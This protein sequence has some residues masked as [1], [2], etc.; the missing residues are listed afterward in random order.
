LLFAAACTQTKDPN[1]TIQDIPKENNYSAEI[2]L[3][4]L[5]DAIKENPDNPE[6][7]YQRGLYLLELKRGQDA[8]KDAEYGLA[9]DANN[10]HLWY[11]KAKAVLTIPNI[12]KSL[13]AAQKAEE[14]KCNSAELMSFFGEV[15]YIKK[16]Y[17]L[18]LT[19]VNRAITIDKFDAHSYFYKGLIYKERR[20]TAKA[21]SSF[22]TVI[23]LK[24]EY[25]DAYNEMAMIN[26]ERGNYGLGLQYLESGLRFEPK[27]AFLNY[28]IGMY[29]YYK[30][31]PDSAKTWY[32]KSVFFDE[33]MY[34]AQYML[35]KIAFD[36]RDY[37][38][39]LPYFKTAA[40]IRPDDALIHYYKAMASEYQGLADEAIAAYS[41]TAS[42]MN[43]Y[44]ESAAKRI[45]I[46]NKKGSLLKADTVK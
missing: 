42:S 28:N 18:A 14:L 11:L 7:Y 40:L 34:Q 22:Q 1:A 44:Q 33:K 10:C 41:I 9:L 19:Y 35:G 45:E 37:E 29:Y 43:R 12:S 8:F 16:E 26:Y 2:K 3:K 27:D 13:E 23:E 25:I 38:T 15:Y 21:M 36:K 24:P 17:D 5:N 6:L 46:L 32:T 20:D 30:G 4:A 31:E 39:A